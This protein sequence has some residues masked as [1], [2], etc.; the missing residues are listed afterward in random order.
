MLP[1]IDTPGHRLENWTVRKTTL[2]PPK[3]QYYKRTLRKAAVPQMSQEGR[4]QV[5]NPHMQQVLNRELG[6]TPP[7]PFSTRKGTET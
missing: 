5:P 2:T 6:A 1:Q 4:R 3:Q 7:E